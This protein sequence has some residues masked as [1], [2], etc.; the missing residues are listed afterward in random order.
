M[1]R[2][3]LKSL[4]VVLCLICFT[5]AKAD[6]SARILDRAGLWETFEVN[7][8]DVSM[9]GVG[10]S[11]DDYHLYIKVDSDRSAFIHLARD[12]WAVPQEAKIAVAFVI[13]GAEI[14]RIAFTGTDNPALISGQMAPEEA[15]V[16]LDRFASGQQLTLHFLTGNEGYWSVGLKGTRRA[17]QVFLRCLST[18]PRATRPFDINVPGQSQPF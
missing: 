14:I 16:L 18:L 17:T 3:A 10:Q 1:P 15:A 12:G 5:G 9:C 8:Q 6:A 11:H 7:E 2:A 13:D 4:G